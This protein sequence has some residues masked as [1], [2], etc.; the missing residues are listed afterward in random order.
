MIFYQYPE[1]S[2]AIRT[3]YWP[4]RYARGFDL[5]RIRKQY[6]LI[7]VEKKR[8]Q[9]EGVD[10]EL[11][12]LLCRHMVNPRNQKAESRFWEAHLKSLQQILC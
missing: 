2:A 7:S 3:H 4:L 12:R 5:A 6:R 10:S 1:W 11:V 8:L 9:I